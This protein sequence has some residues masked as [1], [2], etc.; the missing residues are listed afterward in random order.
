MS[1]TVCSECP[2]NMIYRDGI[3]KNCSTCP[4]G[5][6]ALRMCSGENDTVC[7]VCI[8]G[9]FTATKNRDRYCK[10]CTTCLKNRIYNR[11]CTSKTDNI[12][13]GCKPGHY[14]NENTGNCEKCSYCYPD[15]PGYT[16]H[17]P[18]CAHIS[19][20]LNYTCMPVWQSPPVQL[21]DTP[22]VE[23]TPSVAGSST[24][25][26]MPQTKSQ[27]LSARQCKV[28]IAVT[29]I[30]AVIGAVAVYCTIKRIKGHTTRKLLNVIKGKPRRNP[31]SHT[32]REILLEENG[33]LGSSQGCAENENVSSN[34]A[35]NVVLKPAESATVNLNETIGADSD[36]T[37]GFD[38]FDLPEHVVTEKHRYNVDEQLQLDS[39]SEN[40]DRNIT[41]CSVNKLD[42]SPGINEKPLSKVQKVDHQLIVNRT[43]EMTVPMF[44][45]GMHI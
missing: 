33:M 32:S 9:S 43:H 31:G 36:E 41:P 44:M 34:E 17:V 37:V 14:A 20:N 23:T 45:R 39:H 16:A 10:A 35:L 18:A 12:C 27:N 29:S 6:Y 1:N 7:S 24:V 15:H 5:E 21:V 4:P 25:T 2:E 28:I 8:P 19:M 11:L 13:G 40:D 38:K 42:G 3:C 22:D 30:L 26:I